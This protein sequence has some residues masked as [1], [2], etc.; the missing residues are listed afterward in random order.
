MQGQVRAL[1]MGQ[2]VFVTGGVSPS[3]LTP[4]Y[5]LYYF[6]NTSSFISQ[7]AS[8]KR[9]FSSST[10]WLPRGAIHIG[11][12]KQCMFSPLFA[13]FQSN[14]TVTSILQR[15][16]QRL[17]FFFSPHIIMNQ[18]IYTAVYWNIPNMLLSLA[19]HMAHKGQS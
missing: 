19:S 16:L 9:N 8:L 15:W 18:W 14:Q 7:N 17:F 11:K 4:G 2:R 5:F 10:V 6:Q 3:L 13:D 1:R 12:P